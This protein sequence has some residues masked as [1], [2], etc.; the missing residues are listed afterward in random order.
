VD[1]E[2]A[3][4]QLRAEREA[5]NRAIAALEELAAI[6]GR[7]P[8]RPPDWLRK[9]LPQRGKVRRGKQRWEAENEAD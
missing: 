5:L 8:G 6:R 3:L 7:R 4:K 2:G 1:L 9:L